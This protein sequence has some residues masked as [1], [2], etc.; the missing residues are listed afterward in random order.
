MTFY[1][2]NWN[3]TNFYGLCVLSEDVYFNYVERYIKSPEK[4]YVSGLPQFMNYDLNLNF[5][6]IEKS[7]KNGIYIIQTQEIAHRFINQNDLYFAYENDVVDFSSYFDFKLECS[8][9]TVVPEISKIL[10]SGLWRGINKTK[11]VMLLNTGDDKKWELHR[12]S[13]FRQKAFAELKEKN[14]T[15]VIFEEKN[16][17]H[18]AF[19]KRFIADYPKGI[20]VKM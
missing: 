5:D 10:H 4:S 15:A 19:A 13:Y 7:M 18:I 8:A 1:K 3:F 12:L 11:Y 9:D 20:D 2:L 17:Y 16:L 6:D 14:V